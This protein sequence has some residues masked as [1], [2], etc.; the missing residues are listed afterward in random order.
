M[1]RRLFIQGIAGGI[2]V[3]GVA[4]AAAPKMVTVTW[5]IE[6]FTCVTCAVGLDTLLKEQKGIARSRSSYPE[7]TAVIEYDPKLI[8]EAQIKEFIEE[9]GFAAKEIGT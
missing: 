5:R 1:I 6:G 9:L 8:G 2:G 3:V 7:R 4:A